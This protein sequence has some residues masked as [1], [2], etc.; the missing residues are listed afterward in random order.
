LAGCEYRP[1]TAHKGFHRA[2]DE[3]FN[4][5]DALAELQGLARKLNTARDAGAGLATLQPMAAELRALGGVLGL[6][7]LDPE[8]W[9]RAGGAPG[10]ISDA[11]IATQIDA[12]LA[13]RKAK[14]WAES[15]RIRDDLA[16]A[17]V[18][19]ED[20]PGGITTWRRS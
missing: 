20:K 6:L 15:D 3:D 9:F 11:Q 12:R 19:V 1:E 8:E 10:G 16:A 4:T 17:G 7:Q 18:I 2:M 5:P 14:N 13:A